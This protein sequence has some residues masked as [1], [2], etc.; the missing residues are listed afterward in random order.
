MSFSTFTFQ[1]FYIEIHNLI[2]NTRLHPNA[3]QSTL[4]FDYRNNLEFLYYVQ[5]IHKTLLILHVLY[6]SPWNKHIESHCQ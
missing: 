3:I 2:N 5:T 1:T 4:N 6:N